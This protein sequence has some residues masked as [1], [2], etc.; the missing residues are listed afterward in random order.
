MAC[1]LDALLVLV[2]RVGLRIVQFT[3]LTSLGV[4]PTVFLYL[5]A[6]AAVDVDLNLGDEEN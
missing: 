4:I 1:Q 5:G 3:D 2:R 6:C